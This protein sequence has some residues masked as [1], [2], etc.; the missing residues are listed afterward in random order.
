M[1]HSARPTI[2]PVANIVLYFD[3]L[4]NVGDGRTDDMCENN[5]TQRQWQWVVLLDQQVL[6][7]KKCW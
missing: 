5:D 4:W 3:R 2:L 6:S 7:M 1:I